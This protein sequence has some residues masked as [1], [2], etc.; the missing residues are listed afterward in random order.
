M[1]AGR[2]AGIAPADAASP[3][4]AADLRIRVVDLDG[5]HIVRHC[6]PDRTEDPNGRKEVDGQDGDVIGGVT[7]VPRMVT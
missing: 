4:A 2:V 3:T 6:R 7:A 5:K 1:V